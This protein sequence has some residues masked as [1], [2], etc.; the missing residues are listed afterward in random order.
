MVQNDEVSE[1]VSDQVKV[2]L[3]TLD[4]QILAIIRDRPHVTQQQLAS[5][6][7]KSLSTIQRHIRKL[8]L[9]HIERVGSDK[10]GYWRIRS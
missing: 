8:R 7:G 1:E 6:A 10:S 4:E 9:L 3:D 2:K 5:L